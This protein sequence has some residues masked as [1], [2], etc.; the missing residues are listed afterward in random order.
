MRFGLPENY[1]VEVPEAPKVPLITEKYEEKLVIDEGIDIKDR[2]VLVIAKKS[3]QYLL[4][5]G[6]V[7]GKEDSYRSLVL[8]FKQSINDLSMEFMRQVN[9]QDEKERDLDSLSRSRILLRS[10]GNTKLVR[11]EIQKAIDHQA[12]E[13]ERIIELEE[14]ARR[15]REEAERRRKEEEERRRKEEE[16]KKQEAERKRLEQEA[17]EKELAQK[18]KEEEESRKKQMA[19]EEERAQQ[20]KAQKKAELAARLKQEKERKSKGITDFPSIERTFFKYKQDIIDIKQSIAQLGSFPDDKKL[21]NQ[22]KRKINPKFGQ[23]SNSFA[24]LHKLSNEVV[25]LINIARGH[26]NQLVYHFILNFAAKAIVAQ[27]ETEVTVK[28]TAALPLARLTEVLLR[29]FP[30]F[31]YYLSARFVKKCP[32]I[33]GYTCAIDSEEGR[34]R[35]GW[36]RND[37]KWEQ[38]NKYEERVAGICTTW[39]VLSR[40]PDHA[41]SLQLYS[42]TAT[43]Q[44]VARLLNTDLKLIGNPHLMVACNWWEAGASAYLQSFGKQ[45]QKGLQAL[46]VSWPQALQDKKLPGATA[47]RLLGREWIET[48]NMKQ[49][50]EM[51]P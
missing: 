45:G 28:T 13:V 17:K 33:I 1:S 51:E 12:R 31:D 44:F 36:K 43:W 50:K 10:N 41:D 30:E 19:E 27:S 20:E 40:L 32:Y 18:K 49:L 25:E 22:I 23:L 11:N 9:L 16:R 42:P 21:A 46:V 2:T 8:A 29:S 15:E 6:S 47:L 14:K 24:Q 4:R 35:M 48:G 3:E 34:K 7:K 5:N 26:N 37:N 39:A 38:E